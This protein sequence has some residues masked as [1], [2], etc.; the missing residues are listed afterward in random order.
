[1]KVVYTQEN[2]KEGLYVFATH[3]HPGEPVELNEKILQDPTKLEYLLAHGCELYEEEPQPDEPEDSAEDDR[4]ADWTDEMLRASAAQL[5]VPNY[6]RMKRET[7]IGKL[8]D[9]GG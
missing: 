7:L 4:W 3:F 6:W 1:M 5:N 2:P 8:E 9:A